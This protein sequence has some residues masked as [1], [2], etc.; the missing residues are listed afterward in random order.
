VDDFLTAFLPMLPA[1]D[2]FFAKVLVMT[3]DKAVQ[4]NRLGLLQRVA[5][6]SE[7]TVDMSKLEGF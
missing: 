1:V 6:L 3:E 4:Q 7:G 2:E 5:L